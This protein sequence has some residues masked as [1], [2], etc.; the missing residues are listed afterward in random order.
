MG[1]FELSY[2]RYF[3]TTHY[4]NAHLLQTGYTLPF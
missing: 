2:G 1:A 3:Q 4:G